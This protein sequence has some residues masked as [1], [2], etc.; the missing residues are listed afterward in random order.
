M[1][2]YFF[3]F[4]F[5]RALKLCSCWRLYL[6]ISTGCQTH[7]FSSLFHCF[8]SRAVFGTITSW[9]EFHGVIFRNGAATVAV[10]QFIF[11]DQET[12]SFDYCSLWIFIR[13]FFFWMAWIEWP[14]PIERMKNFVEIKKTK[15]R[16]RK[17][18]AM[19][20]YAINTFGRA[21]NGN[22]TLTSRRHTTNQQNRQKPI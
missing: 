4:F 18:T 20:R 14:W 13:F 8:F 11:V 3:F 17:K 9:F 15:K 19:D 12:Y 22:E 7:I 10:V 2:I 16:E 6:Y 5:P 21:R 1:S